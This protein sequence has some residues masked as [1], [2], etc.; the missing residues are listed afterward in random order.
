VV[1]GVCIHS[2]GQDEML[3]SVFQDTA[4]SLSLLEISQ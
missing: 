3:V 4:I 2:S 1:V